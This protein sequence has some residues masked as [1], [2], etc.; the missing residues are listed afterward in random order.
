V[1]V[2][3]EDALRIKFEEL[4]LRPASGDTVGDLVF[5]R[6]GLEDLVVTVWSYLLSE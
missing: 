3:A 5:Q 6:E 4:F 2:I 1:V